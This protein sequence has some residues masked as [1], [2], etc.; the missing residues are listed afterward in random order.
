MR[1]SRIVVNILHAHGLCISYERILR[2]KRLRVTQGLSE[3]TLNL[4]GH[5]EALTYGNLCIGLFTI[6]AKYNI[7]KTQDVQLQNHTIVELVSH[8]L[9]FALP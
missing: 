4:F 1:R 5:E 2:F 6:G 9:N 7:D 3:V 8:Y